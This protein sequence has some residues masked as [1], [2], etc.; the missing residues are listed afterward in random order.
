MSPWDSR[1]DTGQGEVQAYSVLWK[2]HKGGTDLG[3][4]C[5]HRNPWRLAQKSGKAPASF[6]E[7]LGSWGS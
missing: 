2:N 6:I 3:A 1:G 4:L 5:K 7:G